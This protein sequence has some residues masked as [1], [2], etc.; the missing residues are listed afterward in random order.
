M[1]L[2]FATNN[3]HKLEEAR[4]ILG[5]AVEVAALSETGCRDDIPE[6][7]GTL[8]GNSLM[9]AEYVY[10]RY[11][12]DCFADDTGLEVEALGGAP[13]VYS[14]RYAGEPSDAAANRRKLLGALQGAADRRAR[15]RTVVTLIQGGRVRQVEGIVSGTIATE[16]RGD[17][18]FGYDCLFIPDGYTQTFAQLGADVKNRISHRAR[19][20]QAL[21]RLLGQ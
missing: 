2:V 9:K 15:F 19:A 17:G 7:A 1:K 21:A 11:G 20:M 10:S 13:G 12:A 3:G 8:E 14:A 5:P 16:E 6:T 18:G 4:G